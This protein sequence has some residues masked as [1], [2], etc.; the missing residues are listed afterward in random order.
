M[1]YWSYAIPEFTWEFVIPGKNFSIDTRYYANQGFDLIFHEDYPYGNFTGHNLPIVFY[2]IDSTLSKEHRFDRAK[3]SN[4]ADLTLVDHDDLK[5]FHNPYR[6]PYCVNDKIF[7]TE[8]PIYDRKIDIAYHCSTSAHAGISERKRIRQLLDTL[9]KKHNWSYKS[10]VMDIQLYA[11]SYKTAKIAINQTRTPSN[12]PHRIFD[13]MACGALVL[14]SPLPKIKE[15]GLENGLNYIEFSDDEQLE[16]LIEQ[17]LNN[18]E[19]LSDVANRGYD[20]VM[21]KHTWAVRS[22]ELRS[23]LDAHFSFN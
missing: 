20:L 17:S 13:A 7:N 18:P 9:A 19:E 14:T 2:D 8:N 21:N 15:D 6:L 3:Q 16:T 11:N 22:K 5:Y 23:I 10:G 1:G 12:R 4:R